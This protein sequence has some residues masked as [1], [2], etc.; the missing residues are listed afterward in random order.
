MF[1]ASTHR[2]Q[3]SGSPGGAQPAQNTAGMVCW[4]SR[5]R[6]CEELAAAAWQASLPT[7]ELTAGKGFKNSSK[8]TVSLSDRSLLP[9]VPWQCVK[10]AQIVS[11]G[12][13]GEMLAKINVRSRIREVRGGGWGIEGWRL[14]MEVGDGERDWGLRDWDWGWRIGI[15]DGAGSGN[16]GWE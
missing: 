3:G 9:D 11:S 5:Q 12:W 16:R 7:Q 8:S 15:E 14:R 13:L 6:Q 10:P 2:F 4:L 1:S